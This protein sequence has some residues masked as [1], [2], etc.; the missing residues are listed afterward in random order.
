[1]IKYEEIYDNNFYVDESETATKSAHSIITYLL[2]ELNHKPISVIDIGCG[3]GD[4]LQEFDKFDIK[5]MLGVDGNHV[6]INKLSIPEDKFMVHDLRT[7][8]KIEKKF[9]LAICLEVAEHIEE[10][11]AN[12]L[13]KSI[14]DAS[15]LVLFSAAIPGQGGTNHVNE[16]WPE[17]WQKK[18]QEYDYIMLDYLREKLWNSRNI[19]WWYKQN[20]MILCKESRIK[21][22]IKSKYRKEIIS[23]V[24]PDCFEYNNITKDNEINLLSDRISQAN[25][26]IEHKTEEIY[27]LKKWM[28]DIQTAIKEKNAEIYNLKKE[29]VDTQTVIKKKN[30][31]IYNI[32]NSRSW[33][34]TMPLRKISKILK[35]WQQ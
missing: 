15:D 9:E 10:K 30:A 5:E 1:M 21:E 6:P 32:Q 2:N 22:L 29:I 25:T 11:Y 26:S 31:E 16:K 3:L 7:E 13:V 34:I 8:L 35:K 27:N 20:I 24:H 17:Y 4:F 14:T 12:V 18:F 28:A 23:I 33:K 19:A